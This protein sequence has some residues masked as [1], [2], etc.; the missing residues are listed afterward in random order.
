[1]TTSKQGEILLFFSMSKRRHSS[2]VGHARWPQMSKSVSCVYYTK[3]QS[4]HCLLED[5]NAILDEISYIGW[6]PCL[7]SHDQP[8]KEAL[9]SLQVVLGITW[10]LGRFSD[11]RPGG[12][13]G[14]RSELSSCQLQQAV[15]GGC[16]PAGPPA[17]PFKDKHA[18]NDLRRFLKG[19]RTFGDSFKELVW[20]CGMGIGFVRLGAPGRVLTG[21]CDA[22]AVPQTG[23]G[24]QPR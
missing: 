10:S 16:A 19:I 12:C 13:A 2:G 17:W 23:D 18:P 3:P 15:L 8:K 21:F 4:S 6:A 9:W 7:E 22:R 11:S 14:R 1:M 5:S 24:R 20:L